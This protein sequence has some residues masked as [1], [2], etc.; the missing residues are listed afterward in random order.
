M[1]KV[2]D[3][4]QRRNEIAVALLDIVAEK[5]TSAVTFRAVAEKSGW[6]T[7]V[8]GH[9]FE[10][11]DDLLLGGLRRAGEI[12]GRRQREINN[13]LLGRQ[14][15]EAILEEELPLDKRRLALT[16]IFIFFYAE[17]AADEKTRAVIDGYLSKW[18]DQTATAVR[19]AQ[20]LGDLDSDI[21]AASIATD[22]VALTDGLSIQAMF[23]PELLERLRRSSPIRAWVNR[24]APGPLRDSPHPN[25]KPLTSNL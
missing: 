6:S 4:K 23:N 19:A 8:L 22:L 2:V 21:D 14:A 18:R 13:S 24:L 7:G 17:A 1:P 11:R 3:H 16:R 5:G 25:L 12:A 9:Y 20:E 10:N 15:L